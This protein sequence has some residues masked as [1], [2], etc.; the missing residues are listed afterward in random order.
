[1]LGSI[2]LVEDICPI[3]EFRANTTN[4]LSSVKANHRPLVLTQNGRSA[5]VVIDVKDYQEMKERLELSEQILAARKQIAN[6]EFVSHD[7][8]KKMI[9]DRFAK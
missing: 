3:S 9:A 5:A 2:N 8:V 7:D 6:G 4:L 1:M